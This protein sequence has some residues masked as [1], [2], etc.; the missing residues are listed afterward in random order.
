MKNYMEPGCRD[1]RDLR[2]GGL[3]GIVRN[4]GG[5]L[6]AIIIRGYSI[7]P[8]WNLVCL[9]SPKFSAVHKVCGLVWGVNLRGASRV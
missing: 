2:F 3:V 4:T 5:I 9:P 7:L 6:T 1:V 8:E